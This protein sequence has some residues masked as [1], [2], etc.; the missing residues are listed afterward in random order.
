MKALRKFLGAPVRAWR[1]RRQMARMRQL[2]DQLAE[3]TDVDLALL[4]ALRNAWD[5]SGWS[6]DAEFLF[7]G[8]RMVRRHGGAVLDCGSGLS[9][10]VFATLTAPSG[11]TVYS[12]EQD[13]AWHRH[14]T[15][16]L[17]AL[18]IRNVALWLAPLRPAG[19]CV[20]YDLGARE[21]PALFGLVSVD[22]PA[23]L[24]QEHPD[25]YEGWRGGVVPALQARAI[26]FAALAL[27]DAEDKRCPALLA[28]W[29]ALGVPLVADGAASGGFWRSPDAG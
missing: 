15:R 27:D 3:R 2:L 8:A 13:P 20:W 23:V 16:V 18:G 10:L 17:S 11:G 6:A 12:L 28:R 19:S 29:Q 4:N 24:R 14:M 9:T 26:R 25:F 5:D 7:Y 21:L 1:F 22:G